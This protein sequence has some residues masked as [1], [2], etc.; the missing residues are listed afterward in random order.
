M[1]W[2]TRCPK[3]PS[4]SGCTFTPYKMT[5]TLNKLQIS[6]N[7]F[8]NNSS[9][10]YASASVLKYSSVST[11]SPQLVLDWNH[12]TWLFVLGNTDAN[13]SDM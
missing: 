11:D 3:L 5:L 10:H 2:K 6:L 1:Q 8:P 4:D 12:E 7:A 13:V 9:T